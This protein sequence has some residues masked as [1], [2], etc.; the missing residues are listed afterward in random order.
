MVNSPLIGPYLWGGSFGGYLTF[1]WKWG[2][3]SK[4]RPYAWLVWDTLQWTKIAMENE[5]FEDV[6][7]IKNEDFPLPC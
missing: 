5:H 3:G 4:K 1:P 2:A 6:F 7:P